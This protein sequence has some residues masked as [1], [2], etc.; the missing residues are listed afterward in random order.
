MG[1]CQNGELRVHFN[2]SLKLRFLG[3]KV[4][5]DA[6]LLAYRELDEAIGLTE[7]GSSVVEDLRFGN[8]K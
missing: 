6:G 1:D 5:T 4:A 8:N 7:M 2:P 3:S